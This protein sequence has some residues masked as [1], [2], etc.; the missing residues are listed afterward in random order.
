MRAILLA[1]TLLLAA[2]AQFPALDATLEATD[3]SAPFPDLVPI[4][5]I[6]A[7]ADARTAAPQDLSLDAR[8]AALEA[9]AA[10]LRGR[11]VAGPLRAR[12]R[13]GVDTSA[14]Q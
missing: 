3:R 13:Q 6:L 14:L 9:R 1:A 12:M 4:E 8:I 7:A 5:P 2:C 10:R 11:P